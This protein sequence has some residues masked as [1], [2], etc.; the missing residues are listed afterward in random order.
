MVRFLLAPFQHL[1][2]HVLCVPSF[3]LNSVPCCLSCAVCACPARGPTGSCACSCPC[4]LTDFFCG[5]TCLGHFGQSHAASV[6]GSFF[7]LLISQGSSS[8]CLVLV[9]YNLSLPTALVEFPVS[10]MCALWML[11]S[12]ISV[13]S[14]PL[15]LSDLCE[16]HVFLYFAPLTCSAT[17][18]SPFWMISCVNDRPSRLHQVFWTHWG[19]Q[20]QP[21]PLPFQK[22]CLVAPQIPSAHQP[23]H[24]R[25]QVLKN[26]PMHHP[27]TAQFV[28]QCCKP[29]KAIRTFEMLKGCRGRL[30][31]RPEDTFTS[32]LKNRCPKTKNATQQIDNPLVERTLLLNE[33]PQK[34]AEERAKHP[35]SHPSFASPSPSCSPS[36]RISNSTFP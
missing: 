1:A 22:C 27:V 4:P 26:E 28:V 30:P 2:L 29:T 15:T 24:E 35:F 21:V 18:S 34:E 16:R 9:L 8:A 10:M 31:T 3:V 17:A 7:D 12:W 11:R 32:V 14:F 19:Q 13:V 33:Y 36:R 23:C 6:Q 5:D 25:S 20:R